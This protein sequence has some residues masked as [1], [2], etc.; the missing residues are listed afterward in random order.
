MTVPAS[1]VSRYDR[2]SIFFHWTIAALI[3]ANGPLGMYLDSVPRD[4]R[5]PY[6]N[7]HAIIGGLVLILTLARLV[8]RLI[9]KAPPL[10]GSGPLNVL[11]KLGHAALYIVTLLVPISGMRT[12]WL[13]GRG[14][15]LGVLQIPSPLATNLDAAKQ[16]AEMHEL[17]FF[18][19][20]LLVVGHVA[21]A[22]Y[23]Q[24]VL[25]DRLMARMSSRA[26]VG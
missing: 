4:A 22:V 7:A 3:V 10:P 14:V 26:T 19:M 18:A 23:H 12:M 24:V 16:T 11:A 5:G 8:N 21:A 2:T 13:R 17:F 15:D 25:K 1:D 6:I 20:L 9:N